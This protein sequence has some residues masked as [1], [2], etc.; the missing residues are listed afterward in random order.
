MPES[1]DLRIHWAPKVARIKVPQFY[2]LAGRGIIDEALI[3]DLGLALYLRCRSIVMVTE[4]RCLLCPRCRAEIVCAAARWSREIPIVCAGCGWGASYGQWRDSWRHR[5][6]YGGNAI[7]TFRAFVSNYPGAQTPRDRIVLIDRLINA[8]H[9]SAR[10]GIVF[11]SAAHN[12][13]EGSV[14]QV[15]EL[16]GHLATDRGPEP[17]EHRPSGDTRTAVSG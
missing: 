2:R 11:R 10:R 12:L 5:D 15:L 7:D 17:S 13:I 9:R 4:A 14:T 16:L 6:L 8:V 1:D 3:D